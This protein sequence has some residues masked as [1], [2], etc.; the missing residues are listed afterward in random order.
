M[1]DGDGDPVLMGLIRASHLRDAPPAKPTRRTGPL[2][3][4]GGA[5]KRSS[6][7]V[8]LRRV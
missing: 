1:S 8:V 4:Q 5:M 6:C 2:P 7:S 3:G